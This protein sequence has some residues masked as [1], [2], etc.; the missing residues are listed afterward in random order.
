[1]NRKSAIVTLTFFLFMIATNNFNIVQF[2][3]GGE[4]FDTRQEMLDNY[5]KSIANI[6]QHPDRKD[7]ELGW[8]EHCW[9]HWDRRYRHG[10]LND[11]LGNT[12]IVALKNPKIPR[13][14]KIKS[15]EIVCNAAPSNLFQE[16]INLL[17]AGDKEEKDLAFRAILEIWSYNAKKN[18]DLANYNYIKLFKDNLP[19]AFTPPFKDNT[20]IWNNRTEVQTDYWLCSYYAT[21]GKVYI[22]EYPKAKKM[23]IENDLF[24]PKNCAFGKIFQDPR[25]YEDSNYHE[26]NFEDGLFFALL[27]HLELEFKTEWLKKIQTH[28]LRLLRNGIL[29]TYGWKFKDSKIKSWF[30]SYSSKVCRSGVCGIVNKDYHDS[31]LTDTDRRNIA[32]I[33][34]IENLTTGSTPAG[35]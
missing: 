35:R 20:Y 34:K 4:C 3:Y 30:A 2:A 21:L 15:L 33:E 7:Y 31:L 18:Q 13:E 16:M 32:L 17:K 19:E 14:V 29:S 1:M 8:I 11:E 22:F 23:L 25:A 27:K 12:I 28:Q 24:Y 6:L 5:N 9:Y 26:Y 10:E